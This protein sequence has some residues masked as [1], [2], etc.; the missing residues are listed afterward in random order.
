LQLEKIKNDKF[1]KIYGEVDEGVVV[2]VSLYLILKRDL[3]SLIIASP[4]FK[5]NIS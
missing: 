2:E 4:G 3:D 5:F 1:V